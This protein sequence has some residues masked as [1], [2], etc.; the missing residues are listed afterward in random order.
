MK[1]YDFVQKPKPSLAILKVLLC[2][3]MVS[4]FSARLAQGV[5]RTS[6]P[7]TPPRTTTPAVLPPPTVSQVISALA[8]RFQSDHTV[9]PQAMVP[10]AT[11]DDP[12]FHRRASRLP[13]GVVSTLTNASEF[14]GAIQR[15]PALLQ[16]W[17]PI[18]RDRKTRIKRSNELYAILSTLPVPLRSPYRAYYT[19]HFNEAIND[20][21]R[22]NFSNWYSGFGDTNQSAEF[23]FTELPELLR[24]DPQL[25]ERIV[26]YFENPDARK[27]GIFSQ[28]GYFLRWAFNYPPLLERIG[29]LYLEDSPVSF[30]GELLPV[31]EYMARHADQIPEPKNRIVLHDHLSRFVRKGFALSLFPPM[32]QRQIIA[33]QEL[34]LTTLMDAVDNAKIDEMANSVRN[35][36]DFFTPLGPHNFLYTPETL[37][38]F[39]EAVHSIKAALHPNLFDIR[40]DNK[41][42]D[43]LGDAQRSLQLLRPELTRDGAWLGREI[44]P[45]DVH[46]VI[47]FLSKQSHTAVSPNPVPTQSSGPVDISKYMSLDAFK[48]QD[49]ET[50]NGRRDFWSAHMH[51]AITRLEQQGLNFDPLAAPLRT[52]TTLHLRTPQPE[53][54]LPLTPP[55]QARRFAEERQAT[56]DT[57]N[58]DPFDTATLIQE[59]RIRARV[60]LE[61][62]RKP[63][64]LGQAGRTRQR[65]HPKDDARE[66]KR[67]LASWRRSTE[68]QLVQNLRAF[69]HRAEADLQRIDINFTGQPWH[70]MT[71]DRF[72]SWA[73]SPEFK[74]CTTRAYSSVRNLVMH[75]TKP[76]SFEKL[77]EAAAVLLTLPEVFNHGLN[78]INLL[79]A[80]ES[81]NFSRDGIF[82]GLTKARTIQG[83]E[84]VT[85]LF[86]ATQN[87]SRLSNND[88]TD[89]AFLIH[90]MHAHGDINHWRK[91]VETKRRTQ[92]RELNTD[93]RSK[94]VRRAKNTI[95]ALGILGALGATGNLLHSLDYSRFDMGIHQQIRNR[96]EVFAYNLRRY[97]PEG[98]FSAE[99]GSEES[100][101]ESESYERYDSSSRTSSRSRRRSEAQDNGR[102]RGRNSFFGLNN[103][104]HNV[105]ADAPGTPTEPSFD[106]SAVNSSDLPTYYHV[107][108]YPSF[109][110]QSAV[111]VVP[112]SS[113]TESVNGTV[114]VNTHENAPTILNNAGIGLLVAPDH[115]ELLNLQVTAVYPSGVRAPL[116]PENYEVLRTRRWRDYAIR[117]NNPGVSGVEYRSSYEIINDHVSNGKNIPVPSERLRPIT[118]KLEEAGFR[119]LSRNLSAIVAEPGRGISLSDLAGIISGT[120]VYSGRDDHSV[121]PRTTRLQTETNPYFPFARF[122]NEA[123]DL[124]ATCGT[125]ANFTIEMINEI[126][127]GPVAEV[128]ASLVDSNGDGH[129]TLDSH[130]LHARTG[131]TLPTNE[132]AIVDSTSVNS[133][134]ES[135][136]NQVLPGGVPVSEKAR[137][138]DV[139]NLMLYAFIGGER[140]RREFYEWGRRQQG[141]LLRTAIDDDS[142][143]DAERVEILAEMQAFENNQLKSD[144]LPQIAAPAVV[145]PAPVQ[146]T[147]TPTQPGTA[148]DTTTVTGTNTDTST[149]TN[150]NTNTNTKTK[151][152]T[153]T[154]PR[155]SRRTLDREVVEESSG[156]TA[157]E[158]RETE[159]LARLRGL[160]NEA[161]GVLH[162][163]IGARKEVVA[164]QAELR[165]QK[166]LK[167][168]ESDPIS[169]RALRF[170][171]TLRQFLNAEVDHNG[172][173]RV[174]GT[175]VSSERERP[176]QKEWSD[177]LQEMNR[178]AEESLQ[179]ISRLE[180]DLLP[181]WNLRRRRSPRD[182]NLMLAFRDQLYREAMKNLLKNLTRM[183]QQLN[184]ENLNAILQRRAEFPLEHEAAWEN[185]GTLRISPLRSEAECIKTSLETSL[186]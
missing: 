56:F 88:P 24:R 157:A 38:R 113:A 147:S 15:N 47:G 60:A 172:V 84:L 185:A 132:Q 69:L 131:I 95:A 119:R 173:E 12:Q 23:G 54:D 29:P 4:G 22:K 115:G 70:D 176:S 71:P 26:H 166:S 146:A 83:N 122:R 72:L 164:R 52:L 78:N 51:R 160:S 18:P 105:A 85:S 97:L 73:Q 112:A 45:L 118:Y 39:L 34:E 1:F 181:A 106:V 155:E 139:R 27:L 175:T 20:G 68:R 120:S 153:D 14:I 19:R 101:N 150:S 96:L 53:G 117:V 121:T 144:I 41:S 103:P 31:Y 25:V 10:N 65:P 55:E 58:T 57:E 128:R 64:P 177:L 98:N 36:A 37:Q 126:Y 109:E 159:R 184:S 86:V 76:T 154:E 162:N 33:Q 79:R 170:D 93:R 80:S 63:K 100:S 28:P 135:L 158:I 81:G 92:I 7:S 91:L 50:I 30:N 138:Q 163:T 107:G 130:E 5:P 87:I 161:Y 82:N 40:I 62:N 169:M 124:A 180:R 8:H 35:L 2:F 156:P 110:N 11:W 127:G 90:E 108:D 116:Y 67:A 44:T 59:G 16:H 42:L 152:A 43:E 21:L 178:F 167:S 183:A 104:S 171:K 148:T 182:E 74:H 129:L 143:T 125:S 9:D 48:A 179:E 134:P 168:M 140:R 32:V 6:T 13:E 141:M 114:R 111:E 17:W 151:T 149:N 186:N 142:L 136:K 75:R 66:L 94:L 99:S 102:G 46:A 3:L 174:F 77:E 61:E 89:L 137:Y 165:R 49:S 123:G 133:E 145:M